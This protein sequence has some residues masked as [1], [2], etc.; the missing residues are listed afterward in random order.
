MMRDNF[1]WSVWIAVLTL[2]LLLEVKAGKASEDLADLSWQV[3]NEFSDVKNNCLIVAT[4][5]QKRIGRG[6]IK[7]IRVPEK[8]APVKRHC[9]LSVD[10]WIL[11]NGGLGRLTL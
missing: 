7:C 1:R 9:Y 5:K 6:E 8:Y 10:G 3:N 11:D 4:E 2:V